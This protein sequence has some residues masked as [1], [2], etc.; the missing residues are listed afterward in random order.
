MMEFIIEIKSKI[1]SNVP[2]LKEAIIFAKDTKELFIDVNYN[3]I[4]I[5]DINTVSTKA[6]LDTIVPNPMPGKFYYVEEEKLFYRYTINGWEAKTATYDQYLEFVD[7]Y[8]FMTD[9]IYVDYT[10]LASEWN[11]GTYTISDID[12]FRTDCTMKLMPSM[13]ITEDQMNELAKALIFVDET[14]DFVSNVLVLKS[15]GIV[16][17]IDIPIVITFNINI[18]ALNIVEDNLASDSRVNM[19]SA[20]QG[21]ILNEKI[22]DLNNLVTIDKSSLVG[23]INEVYN[24]TR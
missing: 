1:D 3:R 13:D 23:A 5:N 24:L 12:L 14:S 11:N 10:L 17:T 2:L 16:P 20:N 19:L 8:G 9:E 6:E 18:H 21:R 15:T 22:G 4:K 7:L